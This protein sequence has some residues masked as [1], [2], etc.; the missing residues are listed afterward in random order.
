MIAPCA[1]CLPGS[2]SPKLVKRLKVNIS[3]KAATAGPSTPPLP[4][5]KVT[6]PRMTAASELSAR[7]APMLRLP[8]PTKPTSR[9]ALST[10]NRL[11]SMCAA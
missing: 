2:P 6:P 5:P 11:D 9:N 4:E 8:K 7:S 1:I 3:M 10:A